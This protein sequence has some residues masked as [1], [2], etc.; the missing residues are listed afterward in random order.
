MKPESGREFSSNR[1]CFR[2]WRMAYLL[3]DQLRRGGAFAVSTNAGARTINGFNAFYFKPHTEH[4]GLRRYHAR[5]K[6]RTIGSPL[7]K[8]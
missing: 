2:S 8:Q 5:L 4:G 6:N 1:Y 3:V 7:P